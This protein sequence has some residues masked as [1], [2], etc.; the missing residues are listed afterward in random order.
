MAKG[1]AVSWRRHPSIRGR[2]YLYPFP[3]YATEPFDRNLR[4]AN[5]GEI[6]Q[7]LSDL[8][9]FGQEALP[10]PRF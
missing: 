10:L 7:Q 9:M 2:S 5:Y 1:R 3:P 6:G 4:L 8:T